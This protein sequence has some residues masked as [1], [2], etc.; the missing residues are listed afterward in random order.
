[1][2]NPEKLSRIMR[3]QAWERAKGELHS[4]LPTFY[5]KDNARDGQF[6]ELDE[7]ISKFIKDV[8]DGGLCE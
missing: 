3:G 5:G 1:M 4:M 7:L 2:M 6:D 8:E